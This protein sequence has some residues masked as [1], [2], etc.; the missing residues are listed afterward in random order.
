M[1]APQ[2]VAHQTRDA[3]FL[4]GHRE[5]YLCLFFESA[6]VV[7]SSRKIYYILEKNLRIR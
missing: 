2:K 6:E 5:T 1:V 4:R 3:V 7:L